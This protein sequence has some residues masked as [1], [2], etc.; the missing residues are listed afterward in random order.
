MDKG[1]VELGR[2]RERQRRQKI[3]ALYMSLRTLL[4]LESIKVIC[5]IVHMEKINGG[6]RNEKRNIKNSPTVICLLV[7]G[8]RR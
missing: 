4:P 6:R 2:E 1:V 3:D 5:G 7:V 8:L